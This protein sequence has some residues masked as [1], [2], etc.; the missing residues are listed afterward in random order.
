[1]LT[2]RTNQAYSDND[3]SDLLVSTIKQPLEKTR[4]L[5][6]IK[7]KGRDMQ[8]KLEEM[9]SNNEDVKFVENDDV[10]DIKYEQAEEDNED[11]KHE[12]T[13]VDSN[14]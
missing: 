3:Q 2:P 5:E 12:E 9:H 13:K 10:N 11:N 8:G 7:K 1:V 14:G 4:D 6:E